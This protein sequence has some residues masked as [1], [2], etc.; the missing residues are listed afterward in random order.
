MYDKSLFLFTAKQKAT[1][2]DS[3]AIENLNDKIL[4]D[5]IGEKDAADIREDVELIDGVYG[6]LEDGRLSSRENCSCIFWKCY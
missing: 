3:M 5:K 6:E 1:E 2:E 4:D